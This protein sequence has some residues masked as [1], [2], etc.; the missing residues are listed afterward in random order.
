ML[1][2]GL[3]DF[4]RGVTLHCGIFRSECPV[5]SKRIDAIVGSLFRG[6]SEMS[7]PGIPRHHRRR[8]LQL[9]LD[10]CQAIP[11]FRRP[12]NEKPAGQRA[13]VKLCHFRKSGAGEG[14]RTLD[15]DLGKVV[16]YH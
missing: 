2:V 6:L 8:I 7:E 5:S 12:K 10:R 14:A 11:D 13:F 3:D 15:P 4:L 9:P 16:L 1:S